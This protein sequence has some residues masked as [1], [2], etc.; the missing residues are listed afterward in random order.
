MGSHK[1]AA[2]MGC[3]D[4]NHKR[5]SHRDAPLRARNVHLVI[6]DYSN[7]YS[8]R[9]WRTKVDISRE[10]EMHLFLIIGTA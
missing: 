5:R 2:R 1:P 6:V 9:Q 3:Y 4:D 7:K 8:S 10:N